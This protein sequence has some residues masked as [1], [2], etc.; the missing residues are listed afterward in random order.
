MS[1]DLTKTAPVVTSVKEPEAAPPTLPDGSPDDDALNNLVVRGKDGDPLPDPKAVEMR[2]RESYERVV[3]GLH[4]AADAAKHLARRE[5]QRFAMWMQMSTNL[6]T[7]RKIAIQHAGIED[8]IPK[9][10]GDVRGDAL[11]YGEARKRFR[12]GVK[13]AAGGCRQIALVHRGEVEWARMA[14]KLDRLERSTVRAPL[15]HPG[16]LQAPGLILPGTETRH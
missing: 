3:E 14:H 12:D 5:P 16:P 2:E 7:V 11:D 15:L 10:L 9:A 6:E 13:Q 4:M 8:T 1:D